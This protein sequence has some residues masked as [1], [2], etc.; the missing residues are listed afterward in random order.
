VDPVSVLKVLWHHKI[1][2][3]LVVAL[4]AG[5]AAAAYLLTPRVFEAT[6]S[7]A[8][9]NPD[10]PTA[11]EVQQDP[12]L[13]LL[14]SD[15]PFLRSSDS[16]LIVQ[17]MVT[18]MNSDVVADFLSS[19]GLST[20]FEVAQGGS[21]GPGLLIDVKA[22]GSTEKSAI[23]SVNVLGG[24]LNEELYSVQKVNDADDIYLF[25]ALPIEA[26][27]RATELYS[28]RIRL[29]IV[30][31]VAGFAALFAAVSL[32]RSIEQGRQ[33]RIAENSDESELGS[34]FGSNDLTSWRNPTPA[35]GA[36]AGRT[37]GSSLSPKI[38][39]SIRSG[40]G[41]PRPRRKN[42]NSA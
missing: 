25:S 8:I 37:T 4:T 19:K 35:R 18:K 1:I 15:N 40:D 42:E 3:I 14:N 16:S 11:E 10:V 23:E 21:F 13:G 27:D 30:V 36:R 5:G 28:D 29:L 41:A 39:S 26:P 12:A 17:V 34:P 20:E 32:A 33:R 9:V 24:L 2:A 38:S 22:E 31:V 6:A 7:Y